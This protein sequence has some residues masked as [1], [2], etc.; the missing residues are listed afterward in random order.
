M[1]NYVAIFIRFHLA[2]IACNP[3]IAR[4]NGPILGVRAHRKNSFIS[5]LA[6][7]SEHA[8]RE[9]KLGKCH[10]FVDKLLLHVNARERSPIHAD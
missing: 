8:S 2:G 5:L 3:F 10:C 1:L 4:Y 6:A 7:E 9:L